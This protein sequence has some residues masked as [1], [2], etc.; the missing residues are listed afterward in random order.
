MFGTT[1]KAQFNGKR[2]KR[3]R[4]SERSHKPKFCKTLRDVHAIN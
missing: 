2:R 3:G 1:W 4:N